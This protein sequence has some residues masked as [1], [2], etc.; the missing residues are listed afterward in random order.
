MM[1][2]TASG[3]RPFRFGESD[4]QRGRELDGL[5]GRIREP[6]LRFRAKQQGCRSG[7]LPGPC[8]LAGELILGDF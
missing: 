8:E 3:V 6:G 5:G 4:D 1:S 2:A 7:G